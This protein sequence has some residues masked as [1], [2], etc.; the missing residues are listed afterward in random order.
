MRNQVKSA[1]PVSSP[2]I[3]RQVDPLHE[4]ALCLVQ[5]LARKLSPPQQRLFLRPSCTP[6]RLPFLLQLCQR[7]VHPSPGDFDLVVRWKDD[8]FFLLLHL[9][10]DVNGS[11]RFIDFLDD[12]EKL[13]DFGLLV[14]HRNCWSGDGCW[15]VWLLVLPDHGNQRNGNYYKRTNNP[16]NL[17]VSLHLLSHRASVVSHVQQSMY[18]ARKMP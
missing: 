2:L 14:L 9:S 3:W 6:Q 11:C 10:F 12:T 15:N 1:H 5:P 13:F 8:D 16:I 18:M 17:L 4:V 7:H